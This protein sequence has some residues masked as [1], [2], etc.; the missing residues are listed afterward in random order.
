M[1]NEQFEFAFSR[2]QKNSDL[3]CL[4]CCYNISDGSKCGADS[5]CAECENC[6]TDSQTCHCT[7]FMAKEK[8]CPYYEKERNT[9]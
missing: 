4:S 2:K 3:L 1:E 5:N 8:Q 9:Q 7:Y 6:E